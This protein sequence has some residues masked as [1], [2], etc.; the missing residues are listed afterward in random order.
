MNISSALVNRTYKEGTTGPIQLNQA[1]D[2]TNS[3]YDVMNL[4]E[5]L[6]GS[7]LLLKVG[8]LDNSGNVSIDK[9]S[10]VWPGNQTVQ[11]KGVYISNHLRV[12]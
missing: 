7:R 5:A 3:A 8:R 9:S 12:R 4:N 2:R 6:N 1:G 11:P 10:I